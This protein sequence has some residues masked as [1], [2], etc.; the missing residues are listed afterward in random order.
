MRA[1]G[2]IQA[3]F[4]QDEAFDRLSAY[5]MLV[6]NLLD[7]PGLDKAI[8]DG[9]GIDHDGG[10][11]LA[12]FEAT[13]FVDADAIAQSGVFCGVFQHFVQVVR[14]VRSTGWAGAPWLPHVGTDEDMA[15]K[16]GQEILLD[17]YLFPSYG[18]VFPRTEFAYT[19]D[20][21]QWTH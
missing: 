21:R 13:G 17:A 18:T 19:Y 3:V 11:V 2:R 10:S 12:L 7:V 14:P 16:P 8:P 6:D 5:Q 15:F 9:L 4:G 1:S 20:L